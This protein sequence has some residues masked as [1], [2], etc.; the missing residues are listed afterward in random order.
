MTWL[1]GGL[2]AYAYHYYKNTRLESFVRQML[3]YTMVVI[4]GINILN[5]DHL[6]YNTAKPSTERGI[7]YEY[8][9]TRSVDA[10]HY[11]EVLPKLM[12]DVQTTRGEDK[13]LLFSAQRI[14][15]NIDYLRNKYTQNPNL[16]SFNF[17]EYEEYVSTKDLDLNLYSK[18]LQEK[19][20]KQIQK[21][22]LTPIPSE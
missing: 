18:I 14:I 2:I 21:E 7:D 1:T 9:S 19:L 10:H 20:Q 22:Q 13:A 11:T 6:I 5:F 16:N 8:L 4:L 17:A 15:G 12:S 3:V